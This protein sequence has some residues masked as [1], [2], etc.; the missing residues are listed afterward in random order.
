MKRLFAQNRGRFAVAAGFAAAFVC[1]L[2]ASASMTAHAAPVS[3]PA[4]AQTG[5]V[6]AYAFNEGSGTTTADASGSGNTG[7]L[8][9]ATWATAGKYGAA[10]SF[11]GTSARV[12]I[13][14][15]A[16]LQLT[17]G[18]TLEA[19]VNPSTVSNKWRD[20]IYKGNDNYYLEA[21]SNKSSRPAGGG[22]FGGGNAN[23]FG[24][25]AL[26][27]NAWAFLAVTYDGA[28]LRLYVN[29]MLASTQAKTG[30]IAT[31]TNQLQIGERQ[32]LRPVLQGPDRRSSRLQRRALGRGDPDRHGDTD[33]RLRGHATAVV[34][35][36]ADR[37]REVA[38]ARSTSPG[39][40]R[41]TTSASPATRSGA[42]KVPAAPT[43]HRLRQPAGTGTTYQD[44]GLAAGTS[45]SYEVRAYDAVGNLGPFSS[46]FTATTQ[47]SGDTQPPSAPG[48]LSASVVSAGEIDL[49]WGAA[50]DNVGVTGYQIW[51]CQ[52]AG[53]TNLRADGADVGNRDDVQ[54]PDGCGEHELQ[55]RGPRRRRRHQYGPIL[56]RS[57]GDDAG[58]RRSRR[59]IF[60]RRRRRRH[61]RRC[62]REREHRDGHE[63]ELG[64]RQVRLV[65]L[66]RRRDL[67]CDRTELE[68]A[69]A[70]LRDD[71]G[72]M[73][74]PFDC[75]ERL[76]RR[77]LQGQR[78]LLPRRHLRQR[79]QARWRRHLRRGEHERGRRGR[80]G[81][82]RL[83]VR[84]AHVRRRDLAVVRER[85]RSPEARPRR[86]QSRRPRTRSR[87][88]GTA[89]TASSSPG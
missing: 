55:L 65:T 83:V 59:R 10:L 85:Q 66:L 80:A 12:N 47:A 74:Q 13:P 89:S 63:R 9:N 56:E 82:E 81:R 25:A 62:L 29:G 52:G 6:A 70:Q 35:G 72:S 64:G 76:A 17:T 8:S 44:T 26:A 1:A 43:S 78:Q 27:A 20:V 34:A 2:S 69:A 40:R 4:D 23:A 39:A 73:G 36:T 21:T 42:A 49:S 60:V 71:A 41:P 3:S 48:T 51:R 5:L 88:A 86:A 67:A 50:T 22:T 32:P 54:G 33:R 19:W 46:V 87:S 11:N 77:D 45:Y 14:N 58:Q 24:T 37:L 79:W 68:L 84:G 30:A 18:M 15:A 16:S 75:L 53:C 57:L 31:S 61:C 28:N 38:R 7:T